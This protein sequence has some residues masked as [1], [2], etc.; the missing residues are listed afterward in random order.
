MI[1]GTNASQ[2]AQVAEL[3]PILEGKPDVTK[4]ERIALERLAVT[5]TSGQM[6]EMSR[7][8]TTR[9]LKSSQPV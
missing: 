3:A 5:E 2:T 7:M 4:V 1:A 6:F 9:S 8:S